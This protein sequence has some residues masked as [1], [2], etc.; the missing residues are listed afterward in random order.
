VSVESPER[1]DYFMVRVSSTEAT[2]DVRGTIEQLSSGE[3]RAFETSDSLVDALRAWVSAAWRGLPD[4]GPGDTIASPH[5][6]HGD[7][8]DPHRSD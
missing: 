3:K 1:Y 5:L 7:A 8:A 6:R 2:P 4:H